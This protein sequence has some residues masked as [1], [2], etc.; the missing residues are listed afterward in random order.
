[1]RQTLRAKGIGHRVGVSTEQRTTNIEYRTSNIDLRF[2]GCVVICV[3]CELLGV[4]CGEKA[5]RGISNNEF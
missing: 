1:M 3:L 4:F 2:R 5:K